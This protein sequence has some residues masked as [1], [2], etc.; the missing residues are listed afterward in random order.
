MYETKSNRF[1]DKLRLKLCIELY[2]ES[3]NAVKTCLDAQIIFA[4]IHHAKNPLFAD[5]KFAKAEVETQSKSSGK[6]SMGSSIP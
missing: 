1:N 2:K 4:W 3:Q 6:K 5:I